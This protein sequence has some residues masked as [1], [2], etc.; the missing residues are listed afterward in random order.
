MSFELSV[1]KLVYGGEA[2]GHHQGRTILVERALAGERLEVEETRSAK[3]VVHTRP[4]RVIEAAPERAE[5]PCPYFGRCGGC[6]YQ[7]LNPETQ[8]LAKREI[9][10]ETLRRIGKIT[11]DLDIPIHSAAPWNYRNQI[12]LKVARQPDGGTALGFF[13]SQSHHV[14]PIDSCAIASPRLN[15]ILASLRSD[16]WL[17]RLAAFTAIEL[18]ADDR[19]E[20][21]MLTFCGAGA[22]CKDEALAQACLAELPGVV[23]VAVERARVA[24]GSPPGARGRGEPRPRVFGQPALSY[25]AG[26]FTY[27][28]SPGSFFQGSR[29]LLPELAAAVIADANTAPPPVASSGALA[30]DLFAGVGLF[31]LP[32]ARRFEQV[33]AVEAGFSSAADLAANAAAHAL[34]NIRVARE[35]VAD[36]LRRFA[37]REPDLVV[38]DPPRAGVAAGAL[39]LLAGL[40]P[41][42]IHYVSCSPPTLARDLGYLT[43]HDYALES[44]ELFDFFPQTYHI[45][46]LVRLVRP[47]VQATA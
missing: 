39:K 16:E 30:L 2:L 20:R 23:S 38:L 9:L 29:F 41:R 12:E 1:D 34:S 15:A 8:P 13:E 21:A 3:G 27:R 33:V 4:L 17:Q 45:E 5:P 46:S 37:Q 36:F 26:D 40:Q 35:D 31:T 44:I 43:S 18:L 25:H 42:R 22:A 28:I 6:Q 47:P 24:P 11:W 19:D 10:R 32:L 14:V 7:H